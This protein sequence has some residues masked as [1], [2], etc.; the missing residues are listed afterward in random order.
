[1]VN[2][3]LSKKERPMLNKLKN[4]VLNNKSISRSDIPV[5][6][7]APL[8]ELCAAA[9]EIRQF[10]CGSGV[11]LCSIISGKGGHCSENCKFCAQGS[12]RHDSDAPVF[13]FLDAETITKDCR[14]HAESGV[15]RYSVVTAGRTL[16]GTDFEKAA[17]AYKKMHNDCPKTG[18]CASHGLLNYEQLKKLKECSV[19]R[20][21]CNIETS[22]EHF[23]NI[24]TTHTFEDK[25]KTIKAAKQAGLEICSGGIIG[26]GESMADRV[27][28]AFVL[29][30]LG[31]VSVP[32][33]ILTPIKGTP[34]EKIAPISKEEVLRTIAVFR[35]ILPQVRIRL[36]AGRKNIEGNG[37]K[38]F[39]GG[40]NAAITG[41]MLTTSGSTIKEDINMLKANGFEV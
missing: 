1:M 29:K 22:P 8:D 36:A 32:I 37:L 21:H 15:H 39:F 27:D 24:C 34:L 17:A 12:A 30:E 35:F 31:A 6:L 2:D 16:N 18:L 13:G 11:E 25:I 5:L 20:Y 9:N 26:M 3:I 38:A 41:D 4:D 7:S 23:K 19:T 28:M 10:F 33:N 40:A 14:Y